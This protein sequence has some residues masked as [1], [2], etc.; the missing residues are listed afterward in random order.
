L[1]TCK[2]CTNNTALY[3]NIAWKLNQFLM[4]GNVALAPCAHWTAKGTYTWREWTPKL[5]TS[6]AKF[7]AT[8]PLSAA[9]VMH[10]TNKLQEMWATRTISPDGS[11][12]WLPLTA[13]GC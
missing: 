12:K 3:D 4:Q 6:Y 2:H 5:N 9:S 7:R 11:P 10:A 1:T 13:V 8:Y